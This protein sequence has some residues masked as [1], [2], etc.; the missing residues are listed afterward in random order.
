VLP[1]LAGDQEADR[2][3][4]SRPTRVVSQLQLVSRLGLPAAL[5]GR[6]GLTAA[7]G[8]VRKTLAKMSH[9][10]SDLAVRLKA[11]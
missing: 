11:M 9:A 6:A 4:A 3:Q 2:G 1:G 5:S 10:S 7:R 8:Y